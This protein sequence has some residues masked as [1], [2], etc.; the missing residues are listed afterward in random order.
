MFK[1]LS[2]TLRKLE[3]LISEEVH[4]KE[5]VTIVFYALLEKRF[6]HFLCSI[7]FQWEMLKLYSI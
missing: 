4:L 7:H 3:Q 1:N 2:E 5:K 6:L